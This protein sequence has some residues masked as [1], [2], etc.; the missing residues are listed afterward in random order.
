MVSKSVEK[1]LTFFMPEHDPQ[2][3]NMMVRR[4]FKQLTDM[5]KANI[6]L[7]TGGADVNPFLYGQ[8]R[9][10]HT[11]VNFNRDKSDNRAFHATSV[12][13]YR[14][15][16]CR[17]AQF[18]NVK[19]GGSLYQHVNGH[20]MSGLHPIYS[21]SQPDDPPIL[22]T[23]THHQMMVP[24]DNGVVLYSAR[25]ATSKETDKET[26]TYDSDERLKY[27]DDTEVVHYPELNILC[28]QFH[29]EYDDV[30][31]VQGCTDLFFRLLEDCVLS[32]GAANL[33][34]SRWLENAR[35]G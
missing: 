2:T 18:L 1:E 34:N 33:S 22:V 4:G 15:G 9:H 12:A 29:P 19:A 3:R 26:E 14:V 8:D 24:A 27:L 16:I 17:G 28:C 20:A 5:S 7:F 13:Q 23:S 30:P 31:N 10:P 35:K 11:N 6:V 25:L 32:E 21:T